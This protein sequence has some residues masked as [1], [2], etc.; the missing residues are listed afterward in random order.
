[1]ASIPDIGGQPK[2]PAIDEQ[3]EIETSSKTTQE[4]NSTPSSSTSIPSGSDTQTEPVISETDKKKE[5]ND[6]DASSGVKAIEDARYRKY[7][8]MLQVGV[9]APAVKLKMTA[10]GVD[11]NVL[12]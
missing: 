10:E 8:K 3:N 9:P 11:P 12:E 7:F 4:D 1:M 6:P 5:S 2:E